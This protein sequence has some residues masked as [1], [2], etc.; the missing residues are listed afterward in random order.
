MSRERERGSEYGKGQEKA[1]GVNGGD[2]G[3]WIPVVKNHRGQTGQRVRN[4]DTFTLFVDNIPES[5]DLKWFWWAFNKFGVVRDAFIPY[6]RSKR[7]GNKFGF[8][9]YDCHVAAGMAISKMN[10]VW[11]DDARLFVKEACFGFNKEH[12]RVRIPKFRSEHG[13]E[14]CSYMGPELAQRPGNQAVEE[15][16]K[17]E[18][19]GRSYKQ[20]LKGE[21]SKMGVNPQT[22]VH[23]KPSGNGWLYRS[24]VA[25]MRRV[26][27]M[28]YL[29][30][31]F[32]LESN[33]VAQFRSLG[34]R[35]VLITFQSQEARDASLESQWMRIWFENVKPWRGEP[36]SLERFVWLSVK[37]LPLSAWTAHTFKLIAELWGC[38]IMVD[39]NTLKECSFAEGKVLVATEEKSLIERWIQLEIAGVYYDVKV[40][41]A[42]SFVNPDIVEAHL[43]HSKISR[44]EPNALEKLAIEAESRKEKGDDGDVGRIQ[45][46]DTC[47]GRMSGAGWD[48]ASGTGGSKHENGGGHLMPGIAKSNVYSEDFESWV[49]D[50]VDPEMENGVENCLGS[51]AQNNLV[52]QDDF[53]AQEGTTD[54]VGDV[55]PDEPGSGAGVLGHIPSGPNCIGQEKIIGNPLFPEGEG[56]AAMEGIYQIKTGKLLS[57]SKQELVD[58]DVKREDEGCSGGYMDNTFEFIKQNKGLTTEAKYPYVGQD[59]TCK[60]KKLQKPAAKITGYEDVP[61]NSEKALLQAVANQPVSVAIDANGVDFQFYLSGVYN[62]P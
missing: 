61:K 54:L 46:G 21:S 22:T 49:K 14:R 10:G 19:A 33:R 52:N 26:V 8:V 38:F 41:E 23:V 42:S 43:S 27:S 31:S 30:E 57:L 60:S 20:V 15:R 40:S 56:L 5:K 2:D 24:T 37:G 3:G 45:E 9:R 13:K 58:C 59:G 16:E 17:R 51:L 62:G 6:K 47:W 11:V 55:E 1:D 7:T 39:E 18:Q 25:V 28:P 34:G 29:Q 50:S 4:K 48:L 44:V 12:T 35:Y 53:L 32:N 36:A